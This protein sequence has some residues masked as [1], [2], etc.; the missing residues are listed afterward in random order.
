[1]ISKPDAKREKEKRIIEL[2]INLYCSGIIEKSSEAI[3]VDK[4]YAMN[5]VIF[6]CMRRRG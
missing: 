1:M 4:D 3:R 5:A 6:S 2:M